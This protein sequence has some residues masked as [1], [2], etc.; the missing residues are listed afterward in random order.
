MRF[1]ITLKNQLI[2]MQELIIMSGLY[3]GLFVILYMSTDWGFF[4]ILFYPLTFTFVI[5]YLLP[6]LIL[7]INYLKYFIKDVYIDEDEII[8]ENKVIKKKDVQKIIVY[9][10]MQ[11]YTGYGGT[12][13]A[14]NEHYFWIEMILNN[15]RKIYFTSLLDKKKDK[16]IE[17]CF[18]AFEI[19]KKTVGFSS[20][21]IQPDNKV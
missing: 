14:Y 8:V 19:Q 17:S 20:L 5:I 18:I 3:F 15:G 2:A 7:H 9:A 6:V 1:K 21:L 16:V 13:L 11:Y 4:K 10:T 12:S